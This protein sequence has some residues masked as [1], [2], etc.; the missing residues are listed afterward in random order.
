MRWGPACCECNAANNNKKYTHFGG[1]GGGQGW[2]HRAYATLTALAA[3]LVLIGPFH[4]SPEL[5]RGIV[6]KDTPGEEGSTDDHHHQH[7]ASAAAGYSRVWCCCCCRCCFPNATRH[8][9]D[10]M[11][12]RVSYLVRRAANTLR[13]KW[14]TDD[15]CCCCDCMLP[16]FV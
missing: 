6:R 4:G 10:A 3:T 14:Y 12:V 8:Q 1:G 13:C 11:R 15:A 5:A 16:L 2:G 7:R 9:A